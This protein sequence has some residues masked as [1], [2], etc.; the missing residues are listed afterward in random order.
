MN[1]FVYHCPDAPEHHRYVG[2]MQI[3]GGFLPITS[4]A[5]TEDVARQKLADLWAKEG[6]AKLRK[7]GQ[8]QPADKGAG[9]TDTPAAP[10]GD[11]DLEALFG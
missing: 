8:L 2:R 3:K 10:A 5:S 6:E 9:Q 7:R 1:I 11:P 4:N